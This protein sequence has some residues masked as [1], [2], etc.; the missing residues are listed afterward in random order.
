[1]KGLIRIRISRGTI[2]TSDTTIINCGAR[3][4]DSRIFEK[5]SNE[6]AAS[7]KTSH[8][9]P[10][11]DRDVPGPGGDAAEPGADRGVAFEVEAALV[12]DEAV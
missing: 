6:N 11:G 7:G 5:G 8:V 9:L 12:G 4:Q 2:S 10:L 1:M 3:N